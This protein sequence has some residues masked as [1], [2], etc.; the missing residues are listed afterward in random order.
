MIVLNVLKDLL[1]IVLIIVGILLTSEKIE[2]T[3][4]IGNDSF[5]DGIIDCISIFGLSFIAGF[6]VGL[7]L[8]K[9]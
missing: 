4:K 8:L 5:L 1:G 7:L 2:L 3:M 9:I 6:G